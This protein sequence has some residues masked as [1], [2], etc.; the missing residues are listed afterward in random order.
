MTHFDQ[1]QIIQNLDKS[2]ATVRAFEQHQ[3][4]SSSSRYIY[5]WIVS[6]SHKRNLSESYK[7]KNSKQ[8]RGIQ[9]NAIKFKYL[10]TSI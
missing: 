1:Q 8:K 2:K 6:Y 4:I 3:E 5:V 9:C 10:N 7:N